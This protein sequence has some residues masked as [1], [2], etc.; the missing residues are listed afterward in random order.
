MPPEQPQEVSKVAKS[1]NPRPQKVLEG[2]TDR[3]T[4]PKRIVQQD[5]ASLVVTL[6]QEPIFVFV[7]VKLIHLPPPRD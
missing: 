1:G 6:Y 3:D 5:I 4:Y 2:E 7:S